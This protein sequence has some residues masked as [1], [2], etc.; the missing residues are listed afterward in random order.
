MYEQFPTI[1]LW[2][3]AIWFQY[4]TENAVGWPNEEDPYAGSGDLSLILLKLRAP[5]EG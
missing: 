4:R 5:S 3:G 2:Y 1:P